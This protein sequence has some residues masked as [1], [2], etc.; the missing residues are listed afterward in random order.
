[1]AA[2][3]AKILDGKAM[4][5][6]LKAPLSQQV[7][8]LKQQ[9]IHPRL[10]VLRIGEDPASEVYVRHK[11]RACA[12]V[13]IDSEV[14]HQAGMSQEEALKL[15]Q[16]WNASPEVHGILVQLP[17][18][19]NLDKEALLAAIHPH[20]DVDGFHPMN[21]GRLWQQK[22]A[23]VPCTPRGIMRLIAE[24]KP[25]IRG[26][27]AVVVGRSNI[28]GRPV[29]ELLMQQDATVT[30]CHRYTRDLEQY[31]RQADILVVAIGQAEFIQGAW[32]KPGSIV[33][34]VGIN[35]V[36][37]QL[38]GDVEFKT[39]AERAAAITPVPGGVGPMTIAMLL[40]NTLQCA[41]MSLFQDAK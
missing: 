9:G 7:L 8:L 32:V 31:V 20:K 30:L 25:N 27:H 29:A 4:A 23:L 1:M 17:L 5:A 14:V 37:N 33:I 13:G 39:A 38:V 19:K 28:V 26:E 16:A 12:E 34:D 40:E 11:A 15:I 18:P 22:E 35:R 2:M 21:S 24:A 6:L 41:Q 36:G 10:C 3:S